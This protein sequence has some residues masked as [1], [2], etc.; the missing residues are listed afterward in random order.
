MVGR[1]NHLIQGEPLQL[2]SSISWI[3]KHREICEDCETRRRVDKKPKYLSHFE[4]CGRVDRKPNFLSDDETVHRK[5]N[6]LS[7]NYVGIYKHYFK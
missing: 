3:I 5:T 6:C 1:E 4:T 2:Y 7:V